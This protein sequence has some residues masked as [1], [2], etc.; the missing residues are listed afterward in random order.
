MQVSESKRSLGFE[1]VSKQQAFGYFF[2]IMFILSLFI[3]FH[4]E[5]SFSFLI[6]LWKKTKSCNITFSL[7]QNSGFLKRL[8][9]TVFGSCFPN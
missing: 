1:P 5:N 4:F 7:N 3:F 9:G 8:L 2:I 6:Q